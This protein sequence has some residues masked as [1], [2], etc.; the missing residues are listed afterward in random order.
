MPTCLL[1]HSDFPNRICVDGVSHVLASRKFCLSCSPWKRHNTKDLRKASVLLAGLFRCSL[2]KQY[3][4]REQFYGKTEKSRF[5]WCKKC[6]R[7][8]QAERHRRVKS[9][10]VAYKGGS[11]LVC[12]YSFYEGG[13]VFHHTNPLEKEFGIGRQTRSFDETLKAEL[14]KC[15]LLCTR[16]HA[17]VHAGVRL[18]SQEQI[19]TGLGCCSEDTLSEGGA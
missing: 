3:L 9:L 13:L 19:I 5:H 8:R 12:G 17:E 4:P 11:C 18:L 6:N 7:D 14:D 10:A 1:C 16:C 2:C 15:L